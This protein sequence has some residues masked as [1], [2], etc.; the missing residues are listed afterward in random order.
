MQT[1]CP[2]CNATF[3]INAEQLRAARGTVQ[4]GECL[5]KFNALSA[6]YETGDTKIAPQ[7]SISASSIPLLQQ[8]PPPAAEAAPPSSDETDELIAPWETDKPTPHRGTQFFWLLS[9]FAALVVLIGQF[10]LN[11]S[12]NNFPNQAARALFELGCEQLN[13]ELPPLKKVSSIDVVDRSMQTKADLLLLD[14]VLVNHAL[15]V[16]PFPHLKL[17][18]SDFKNRPIAQRI[19]SA[20]EYLPH[21]NRDILMAIGKPVGFQLAINP[22]K[23]KVETFSFELL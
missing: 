12:K 20:S 9:S 17:T 16:Q 11:E 2:Q 23:E 7:N 1:K 5:L 6:L 4:C 13:C 3:P 14:I 15:H 22:T 18:L 10:Y 21:N 19:F 8:E